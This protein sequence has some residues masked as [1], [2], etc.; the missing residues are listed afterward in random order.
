MSDLTQNLIPTVTLMGTLA[1]GSGTT[2]YNG[3][4]NK[5]SI[6]NVTLVGNKTTADL[7][8]FSGNYED[9]TNKPTIPDMTIT[10][11][12]CVVDT[13]NIDT[14]RVKWS[15]QGKIVVVAGYIMPKVSWSGINTPVF[16]IP[17]LSNMQFDVI[18]Q[19]DASALVGYLR[20]VADS[21]TVTMRNS[22]AGYAYRFN[23]TYMEQ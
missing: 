22:V 1:I 8:L 13:A 16:T 12:D 20:I 18:C 17:S 7:G 9:L 23:F 21:T 19:T 4:E 2:D 15:K 5:P 14:Y 10:T 6:N 11:G 3:L